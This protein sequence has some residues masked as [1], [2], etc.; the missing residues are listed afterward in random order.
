MNNKPRNTL[1]QLIEKYG[2][3]LCGDA[4]R[5][6]SL[7]KDLCGEYRR[8]IS[9][10]TN[11]IEERVPLDL[12][13]AN[14]TVPNE[15]LLTKLAKRLED[16]LGLTKEA[17]SWAVASWAFALGIITDSEIYEIEKKQNEISPTPFPK[18]VEPKIELDNDSARR[19]NPPQT[20][21]QPQIKQRPQPP[22]IFPPIAKT[23]ANFP[24]T[25]PKS[26]PQTTTSNANVPQN[27]AQSADPTL[28]QKPKRRFGKFFGCLF[29]IV[30][31]ALT[32]IVLLF[33]VPYAISVMRETQQSEP[34]RF[35]PR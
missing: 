10:L 13:A 28:I 19:N 20:P 35:P 34:P 11:A 30:F 7:L 32:G 5:C 25:I 31:L 8:E 24:A 21:R 17:S 26:P 29:V 16:N 12:L 18:T 23:P 14:K 27:P 1:R 6:E 9:V 22:T 15:L 3:D 2:K 4:R 33:G